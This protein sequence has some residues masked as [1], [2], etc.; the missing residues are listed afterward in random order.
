MF[1]LLNSRIR[2]LSVYRNHTY[3]LRA[4]RSCFC[5]LV[6]LTQPVR[7]NAEEDAD[8]DAQQ[9][10]TIS[11][12]ISLAYED[13]SCHSV[14]NKLP[15]SYVCS[16]RCWPATPLGL[17]IAMES[18]EMS[19]TCF[20]VHSGSAQRWHPAKD[21]DNSLCYW[22][23]GTVNGP[24]CGEVPETPPEEKA[25]DRYIRRL[26]PCIDPALARANFI[27]CGMGSQGATESPSGTAYP[28]P[29]P[30][31]APPLVQGNGSSAVATTPAP[32]DSCRK[33]CVGGFGSADSAL[34]GQYDRVEDAFGAFSYWR[35]PSA[36][37][38]TDISR[39]LIHEGGV[40]NFLEVVPFGGGSTSI[41]QGTT[42]SEDVNDIP[43]DDLFLSASDEYQVN[44]GCCAE[45]PSVF[46]APA[47]SADAADSDVGTVGGAFVA[48]AA[49]FL[50]VVLAVSWWKGWL[51]S[52]EVN[53][54][55]G[56]SKA[57]LQAADGCEPDLEPEAQPKMRGGFSGRGI[58]GWGS[59]TAPAGGLKTG[60]EDP[61][62]REFQ[63]TWR[64]SK[65]AGGF[66]AKAGASA[67]E[68]FGVQRD[69]GLADLD[70]MLG[71][72]SPEQHHANTNQIFEGPMNM[73]WKEGGKQ[74]ANLPLPRE[75]TEG[76]RGAADDS[77]SPR[78]IEERPPMRQP[79][80]GKQ[81]WG[82]PPPDSSVFGSAAY[83]KLQTA[84]TPQRSPD[85]GEIYG[86]PPPREAGHRP[87]PPGF[88]PPHAHRLQERPPGRSPEPLTPLTLHQTPQMKLEPLA[89]R[90]STGPGLPGMASGPGRGPPP[91]VP[92]APA[93][94]PQA[95]RRI[96]KPPAP[97]IPASP[98][99]GAICDD[100]ERPSSKGKQ[101]RSASGPPGRSAGDAARTSVGSAKQAIFTEA[102]DKRLEDDLAQAQAALKMQL[103]G[104]K[105]RLAQDV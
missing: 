67:P 6:L 74:P 61:V 63:T 56:P 30:T 70:E 1:S 69:E 20:Q 9:H 83:N 5:L 52:A 50:L 18:P 101:R 80:R 24:R 4:W 55:G 34:N 104:L 93:M 15:G 42:R 26:C 65:G 102:G 49:V 72:A 94:T 95:S 36:A 57:R 29:A 54:R 73:W 59:Q 103:A 33:L 62:T 96:E 91:P 98:L 8:G 60:V 44:F 13:E 68:G 99:P 37:P 39:R 3:S 2:Q 84:A 7:L 46:L 105:A 90:P 78:I 12:R 77:P 21:P 82:A 27:D 85:R 11:W 43:M 97:Q 19:G 79:H 47:A 28:T 88:E 48:V 76:L 10:P 32:K 64:E 31:P 66:V 51:G 35:K 81:Q 22:N 23:P 100:Q 25:D 89:S 75:I 14:C 53:K 17:Q 45:A 87:M 58:R 86:S 71:R 41:A 40:W 92:A 16:E 38:D